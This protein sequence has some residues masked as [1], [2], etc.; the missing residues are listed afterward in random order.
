MVTSLA[1]KLFEEHRD[2]IVDNVLLKCHSFFLVPMQTELWGVVQA[3]VSHA[4]FYYRSSQRHS[5]EFT[6]PLGM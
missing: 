4:S 2:R 6:T 1:S 3:K 5:S